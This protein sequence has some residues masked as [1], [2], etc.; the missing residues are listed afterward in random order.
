MVG[1]AQQGIYSSRADIRNFQDHVAAFGRGDC[2]ECLTFGVTFRAPRRVVRLLNDSLPEAFG[3]LRPYNHGLAPEEGAAEPFLQARYEPLVPGPS[4]AEG[5]AWL[6]PLKP[7]AVSGTQQVGDRKLA[8]EARQIARLL[9]AGGPS[10]VGARDWGD[11]CVLAPRRAWLPIIRGEFEAAGLAT[12]LQMRRNRNGDNP[13]Y[14]WMCGLLAV[15]C[16]PDNT[17]EWV[18]VLREVFGVSDA[19]IAQ[20]LRATGEFR[21]DEPADYPGE[22]RDALEVEISVAQILTCVSRSTLTASK[23]SWASIY[24]PLPNNCSSAW[25]QSKARVQRPWPGSQA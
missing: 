17:F 18:G 12:A 21:W 6:L 19:Q 2:G 11:I 7:T 25:P 14:A 23:A 13:V 9:A 5:G 8:G 3:P 15:A 24:L 20:A 16:D 22:I 10:A 1:D 4:N